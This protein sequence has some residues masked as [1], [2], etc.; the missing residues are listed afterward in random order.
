MEGFLF[1]LDEQRMITNIDARE[2]AQKHYDHAIIKYKCHDVDSDNGR[3]VTPPSFS[4]MAQTHKETT[5]QRWLQD[6]LGPVLA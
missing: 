2:N 6:Y 3:V 1:P 5:A 4:I